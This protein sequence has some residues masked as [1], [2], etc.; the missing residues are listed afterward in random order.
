MLKR[1]LTK[2]AGVLATIF[3]LSMTILSGA[4]YTAQ[5]EREAYSRGCQRVMRD[6][7]S[8]LDLKKV[9]EKSLKEYCD[10]KAKEIK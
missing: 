3:F 2:Y 5:G 1:I 6:I 10:K 9:D 7:Y 8:G 4:L